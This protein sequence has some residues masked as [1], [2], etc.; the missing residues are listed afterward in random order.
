M[1]EI[2]SRSQNWIIKAFHPKTSY[3][4]QAANDGKYAR[5][6]LAYDF[7]LILSCS[8]HAQYPYDFQNIYRAVMEATHS[9]A[10]LPANY[11]IK[12]RTLELDELEEQLHL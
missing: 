3:S 10:A 4:A 11:Q 2:D 6:P 5:I 7:A 8:L 9:I 1:F 12:A